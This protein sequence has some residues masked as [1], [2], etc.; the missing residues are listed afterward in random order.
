MVEQKYNEIVMLVHPLFHIDFD[1]IAGKTDEQRLKDVKFG[2]QSA[3]KA[4][5][6]VYG[7]VFQRYA[8][9]PNA[10]LVVVEPNFA[11]WKRKRGPEFV[12]RMTEIYKALMKRFEIFFSN[13][14]NFKARFVVTNYDPSFNPNEFLP[15]EQIRKLDDIIKITSFGEFYGAC[16]HAWADYFKTKL[17]DY[18][19]NVAT[20]DV[21]KDVSVSI[22]RKT[23]LAK[24]L[25]LAGKKDLAKFRSRI[26]R[27]LVA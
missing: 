3:L 22:I 9:N 1:P 12:E 19:V 7:Q 17:R 18:N 26:R 2:S 10:L 8:E 23:E 24:R 5:L 15:E 21:I 13:H 27:T 25:K 20:I 16:T 6:G 11:V 4:T 14:P